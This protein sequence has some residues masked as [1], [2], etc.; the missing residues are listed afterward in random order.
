MTRESVG[1][2]SKACEPMW[3]WV[4]IQV[5]IAPV[6]LHFADVSNAKEEKDMQVW[7]LGSMHHSRKG[8]RICDVAAVF[9]TQHRPTPFPCCFYVRVTWL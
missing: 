1:R 7:F 3:E 9:A 2:A 8:L 6:V 4:C 5:D